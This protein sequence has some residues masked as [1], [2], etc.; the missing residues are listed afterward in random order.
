VTLKVLIMRRQK[1]VL[2]TGEVSRIC[3]VAPRTVSKWFDS[4]K[5]RGYRI[6]GSKDRRIPLQQL[7]RFMRAHG[8]PLDGL[9][10]GITR[11]LVV[12]GDR[13]VAELLSAAL[14]REAG[15]EVRTAH[16]AF[17]A[18]AAAETF[19]PQVM[20][21][22]VSLPGLAGREAVRGIRNAPDLATAKLIAVTQPLREGESENLRQ[23]GFDATL[24]RPF[25]VSGAM[26]VIEQVLSLAVDCA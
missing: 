22:D 18:G 10:S 3:N 1:D 24:Q 5:L 12:E 19:K 16:T 25:E 11:V 21:L 2:T 14:A 13:D 6:P 26:G 15:Y 4:G 7:I 8:I 17:E 20:L 9:N 23:Q